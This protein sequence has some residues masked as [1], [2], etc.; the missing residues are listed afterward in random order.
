MRSIQIQSMGTIGGDLCHLPNCWYF[1]NGYGL[2]G[3][4][5][6]ES[7]PERGDNRYHAILGNRGPAKFVSA[8]RFAPPFIAWSATRPRRRPGGRRGR[9]A[10]ARIVL[11]H[12]ENRSAR[13]HGAEARPAH[14]AHL[15]P[16]HVRL[17]QRYV[18]GAR[19]EGLDW[20]LAAAAACINLQEG[21]VTD[22]RIVLGH[23]APIPWVAHEA[24]AAIV[25]KSLTEE[26]AAMAGEIAVAAATP[27]S[28]NGYKVQLGKTSVKR[29][30]L[31]A[32][33]MLEGG[34]VG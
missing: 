1:R 19:I 31:R 20:P 21:Q 22:A 14:F 33:G 34:S 17:S 29:A 27:L 5:N 12:A 13:R 4:E 16:R 11:H 25:G 26:T 8:S 24:A 30:L 7:L 32:A 2:L 15:A 28:N 23:V 6:G 18:R 9:M 10:S 3:M